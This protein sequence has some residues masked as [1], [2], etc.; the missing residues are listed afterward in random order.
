MIDDI[1]EVYK[2]LIKDLLKNC[3]ANTLL[4]PLDVYKRQLVNKLCPYYQKW[5]KFLSILIFFIVNYLPV[6]YT[7]LDVY[8]RQYQLNANKIKLEESVFC[9]VGGYISVNQIK[10]NTTLTA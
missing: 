3:L 10:N 1:G 9:S 7:H 5:Q 2:L 8:K 6:S 4:E